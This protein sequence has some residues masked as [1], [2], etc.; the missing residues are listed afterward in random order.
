MRGPIWYPTVLRA[1]GLTDR[2]HA[3]PTN[4]D[5]FGIDERLG[6]CI[7]ADGMGGHNAGEVAARIAVDTVADYMRTAASSRSG[8]T[9]RSASTLRSRTTAT[10]CGRPSI[11]R[12]R[13]CSK[14]L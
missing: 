3:R 4:E 8:H 6:L 7:V 9:A 14:R 13:R 5:C 2:G 11:W 10:C 12:T 1:Y